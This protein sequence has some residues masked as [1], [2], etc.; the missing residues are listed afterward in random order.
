MTPHNNKNIANRQPKIPVD[1]LLRQL[2]SM[3][4]LLDLTPTDRPV[5]DRRVFS[6]AS[7]QC[8]Q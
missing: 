5:F 4:L 3:E 1:H 7:D 6:N 2:S 8:P